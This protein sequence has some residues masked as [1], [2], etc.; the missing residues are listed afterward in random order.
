MSDYLFIGKLIPQELVNNVQ[1]KMKK[2]MQDAALVLQW[3]I[4]NG[5]EE[6]LDAPV[7]I[8]SILPIDSYPHN[9]SDMYIKTYRFSH[10]DGAEDILVGH[11]NIHYIRRLTMKNCINKYVK[12]WVHKNSTAKVIFLY[13]LDEIFLN[14]ALEAKKI[15]P[16]IKIC[17]IIA[18]LPE[19]INL[20]KNTSK[21]LHLYKK[22]NLGQLYKKIDVID[23]YV[24]L[25]EQM[26]D[27]LNIG[28]PYTVLE[29]IA[30]DT[31]GEVISA[32]EETETK[33]I[34]YA[35]TL[36]QRFGVRN[37]VEAFMLIPYK[38][39]RLVIC[40]VGD[41][42]EWILEQKKA[43][44]RIVFKGRVERDEVLRLMKRATVIVNPRQNKGEFVKYSFPSK[45][46]EALSSGTPL[47]AYKLDGIPAEYENYIF[48]V[49]DDT[50][51]GF[52]KRIVEICEKP[53]EVRKAYAQNAKEFVLSQ[54]NKTVQ[55]K[56]ILEMIQS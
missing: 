51:N 53:D 2:S 31:F 17:C 50:I 13:T 23:N 7:D 21:L 18:D 28:K 44:E 47:I 8:C 33:E 24:L 20:S 56:K 26:A 52:S 6:N 5:L 42:E 15:S 29:G 3:N 16:D 1:A 45:N 55:T 4:I 27:K 40:G 46:L 37:L 22:Y 19:F 43:D 30:T 39:Y 49:Q 36:H 48:Y 35:G 10:C 12:E 54:K 38:N 41:S 25:T 34:L 9:Y 14:A 32:E 11:N